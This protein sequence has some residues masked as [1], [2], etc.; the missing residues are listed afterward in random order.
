MSAAPGPTP[1]SGSFTSS[2]G[3]RDA[4]LDE[5]LLGGRE[6]VRIEIAEPDP[7]WANRYAAV[8]SELVTAL[9]PAALGVEHIGSTSVPGLAAKPIIDV[10]LTVADPAVEDAY[11]PTLLALGYWLRVREPGHRMFRTPARD[12]HVHVY[13][14][15]DPAVAAHLDLRDWLRA[16]TAD[17]EL[18]AATKRHLAE[19]DWS[20]MNH[21]ADAKSEVIAAMLARSRAWRDAAGG[22]P[23]SPDG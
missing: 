15:D 23:P 13:A 4:E 11:A 18:Y 5:V 2:A 6:P 9:G 21:Y 3:A 22:P 17:R 20:D 14:P 10:L 12:V 1:T 19:R 8:R 7:T 16:D